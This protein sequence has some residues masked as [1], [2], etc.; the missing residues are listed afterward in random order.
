[1][2]FGIAPTDTSASMQR[3]MQQAALDAARDRVLRDA[4]LQFLYRRPQ[5]RGIT[6][7]GKTPAWVDAITPDEPNTPQ[8]RALPRPTSTPPMWANNPTKTRRK[9]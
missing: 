4:G 2:N 7:G 1:M 9:R 3:A 8:Q 6:L 5:L